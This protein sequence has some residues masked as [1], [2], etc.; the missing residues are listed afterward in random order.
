[1]NSTKYKRECSVCD[2]KI[3]DFDKLT[4]KYKKNGEY[5]ELEVELSDHS[6]MT[7]GVCSAHKSAGEQEF[8][9]MTDRVHR[10]WLEEVAAGTG[11][12]QWV[13][14]VGLNL[15]VVAVR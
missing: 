9:V 6:I 13:K 4:N 10:G 1:M 7:V 3:H 5:H 2:T 11:N 14:E 15:E 8:P 12:K